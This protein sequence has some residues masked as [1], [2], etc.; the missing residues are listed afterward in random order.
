ME[1]RHRRLTTHCGRPDRRC[2]AVRQIVW[3]RGSADG[4]CSR[5]DRAEQGPEP[6][7]NPSVRAG[8]PRRPHRPRANPS[9]AGN[10]LAVHW[11]HHAL[12]PHRQSTGQLHPSA[13]LEAPPR[14]RSQRARSFITVAASTPAG[15]QT[16]W[17]LS[18]TPR[19][20]GT[21]ARR[22]ASTAIRC[23]EPIFE[24]TQTGHEPVE[25]A[26]QR[27]SGRSGSASASARIP[28]CSSDADAQLAPS[29][30]ESVGSRVAWGS[31]V[32]RTEAPGPSQQSPIGFVM[33]TCSAP[34]QDVWARRETSLDQP[35]A[36]PAARFPYS[37][38]DS[39][40]RRTRRTPR[41]PRRSR[42]SATRHLRSV[43]QFTLLRR[44]IDHPT[45]ALSLPQLSNLCSN[46]SMRAALWSL[47]HLLS[48]ARRLSSSYP[49]SRTAGEPEARVGAGHD[50]WDCVSGHC[51]GAGV[52]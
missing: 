37:P 32:G 45:P 35:L 2:S 29:P 52:L 18:P 46:E 12:R 34:R 21:C 14:R 51:G 20:N 49:P 5:H 28:D 25:L 31:V 22:T 33:L 15:T 50:D 40:T 11:D 26:T 27:T 48:P 36:R 8:T 38:K 30:G 39:T 19:T 10:L 7:Q 42:E 43:V 13:W 44:T 47:P 41:T 23:Q 3:P 6:A 16:I 4:R 17:S 24:S 9:A 1:G